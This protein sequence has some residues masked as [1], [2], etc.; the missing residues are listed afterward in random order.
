MRAG[1]LVPAT[2]DGEVAGGHVGAALNEG[3]NFS[4][5]NTRLRRRASAAV[6]RRS[7]RAGTLV[8]ATLTRFSGPCSARGALNEGRNFSSGNTSFLPRYGRT[9]SSLNEGRNF[10]SGNTCEGRGCRQ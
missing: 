4:S 10:S 3:R 2:P 9:L 6:S 5:G 1:T 8:P 7:M